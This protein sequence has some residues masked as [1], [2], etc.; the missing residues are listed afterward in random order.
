MTI[1]MMPQQQKKQKEEDDEQQQQQH[2]IGSMAPQREETMFSGTGTLGTGTA[3]G[4]RI[5]SRR[6]SFDRPPPVGP[7]DSVSAISLDEFWQQ[8]QK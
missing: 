3:G 7:L 8:N 2:P 4:T 5:R 6:K 1:E